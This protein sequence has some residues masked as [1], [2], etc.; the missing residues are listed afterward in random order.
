MPP[1]E[2]RVRG[3][4]PNENAYAFVRNIMQPAMHDLELGSEDVR[5]VIIADNDH[6]G[7]A[8]KEFASKDG[9]T[10]DSVYQ[11]IGKSLPDFDE[12][13]YAG[14]CL[15]LHYCV[16]ASSTRQG[17][18]GSVGEADAMSYCLFHELGHCVDYRHRPA[19]QFQAHAFDTTSIIL[20]CADA[21][22]RTLL[23]EYAACFFSAKFM[24]PPAFQYI[25]DQ[26]PRCSTDYLVDL[27]EKRDRYRRG[28]LSLPEVRDAALGA[29]WRALI[30]FAKLMAFVHG[31]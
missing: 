19:Q 7:P 5:Q 15:V 8:I 30:E 16:L 6:Y 28:L 29:F 1:I 10:D 31:N 2:F 12:K 9:F 18:S 17:G 23:A 25:A 14:S 26:T 3:Y 4:V 21:N 20:G 24:T 13:G 27:G 22:S 11:G